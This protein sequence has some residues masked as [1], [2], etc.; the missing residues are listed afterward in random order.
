MKP[1]AFPLLAVIICALVGC[2]PGGEV[3]PTPTDTEPSIAVTPAPQWTDE[4]Q[5]AAD[6]VQ[7]YIDMWAY[8]GQ[9]IIE[10]DWRDILEVATTPQSN[11]DQ[12]MWANWANQGWH[13]EGAP[14]FTPTQ[15]QVGMHDQTGQ[16]YYVF[17]CFV[18]EDSFVSDKD[19]NSIGAEGRSE[20]GINSYKVVHI[21]Q[22][23]Y[24]VAES[25]MEDD[26][27]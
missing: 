26:L 15:V 16:W 14:T 3:S 8:I 6:A 4:E 1:W 20:R 9:N 13:L 11:H 24:L 21:D 10:A 22:Q 19:G 17:G 27:C 12:Q 25:T 5:E 7:R 18:I 23:G 2:T